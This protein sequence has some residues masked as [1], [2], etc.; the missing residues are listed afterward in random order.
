LTTLLLAR[1]SS[2]SF[3]SF[4]PSNL[5][6][7]SPFYWTPPSTVASIIPLPLSAVLTFH[8]FSP[9]PICKAMGRGPRL[10]FF[11]FLS[12]DTQLRFSLMT[13]LVTVYSA[14]FLRRCPTP[15]V[16]RHDPTA[17]SRFPIPDGAFRLST[18]S[19]LPLK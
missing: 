10:S 18:G 4:S 2:F 13:S 11:S 8:F 17:F 14:F 5:C 19:V 6:L 12:P 16:Q 9:L 15:H 7:L 3:P 1:P